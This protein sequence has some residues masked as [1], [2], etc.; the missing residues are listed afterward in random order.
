MSDQ[1]ELQETSFD[2]EYDLMLSLHPFA[3]LET[4]EVFN[5]DM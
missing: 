4:T 5:D 3:L 1:N 2:V